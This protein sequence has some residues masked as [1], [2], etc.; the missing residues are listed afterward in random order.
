MGGSV[1]R[2]NQRDDSLKRIQ[3][4]VAGYED[5]MKTGDFQKLEKVRKQDFPLELPQRNAPC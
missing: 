1:K 2:E 4:S 3:P 5:G